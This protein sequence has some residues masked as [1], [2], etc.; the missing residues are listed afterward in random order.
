MKKAKNKIPIWNQSVL[1]SMT[2]FAQN[3]SMIYSKKDRELSAFFEIGCFLSLIEFYEELGFLGKVQNSDPSDGSYKYLTTPAG[4]PNNFSYMFME[5]GDEKIEVRQQ[6][7]ILSHVAENVAFTPDIVVMPAD[8]QIKKE[9]FAEYANGKKGFFHVTSEKVI[10]AHE[11]KSLAP[12]PELLVSFLGT[13]IA[14]HSWIETMEYKDIITDNGTHLAPCLFVGG[15]ARALHLKMIEGLKNAYPL[16]IVVGMHSGTWNLL[17][18]HA[19]IK[20]MKNPLMVEQ[21]N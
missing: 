20:K 15:S 2:N 17:G 10:A 12:F 11:C 6:V 7:R 1:Q 13:I 21:G 14:A 9:K 4:N 19:D 16:N 3:Y 18:D 5:N 8:T